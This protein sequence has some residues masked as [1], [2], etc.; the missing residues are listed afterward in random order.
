MSNNMKYKKIHKKNLKQ[1]FDS[2]KQKSKKFKQR[3]R[4]IEEEELDNEYL[5][6][7]EDHKFR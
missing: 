4:Y 3:K 2:E 7:K 5:Y 6:Y 1:D